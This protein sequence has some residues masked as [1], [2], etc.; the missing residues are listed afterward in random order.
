ME[1]YPLTMRLQGKQRPSSEERKQIQVRRRELANQ[2]DSTYKLLSDKEEALLETM[3]PDEAWMERLYGLSLESKLKGDTL[4]RARG[5]QLYERVDD[6]LRATYRGQR[7]ANN[8]FPLQVVKVGDMVPE[9]IE[10]KD[11]LGNSH[12]LQELR[13]KFLL[14][15]FW[16]S[17]C[18]P[19]I[20]SFPEMKEISKQMADSLKVVSISQDGEKHWKKASAKYDITWHNW[21]DLQR[22]NG[23]FA[24]FGVQGIPD[25]FLVSPEGK[26]IANKGGYGKGVLKPFVLLNMEKAGKQPTYRTE[27]DKRIIDYPTVAEEHIS[28][29]YIRRVELT[30]KET[31]VTFRVFYPSSQWFRISDESH[32]ITDNGEKL[33]IRS[34]TNI[35]LNKKCY[36]PE[37]N[38]MEF[39][40]HFPALPANAASFS[41]YEEENKPD[42]CWRMIGVKVKSAE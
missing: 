18:G 40:L 12:R 19:C 36:T 5:I 24:R 33:P 4:A 26:V 42:D 2:L 1:Y 37:S 41:Y 7:I 8:L 34:A 23:I 39:T 28:T 27:G 10:L 17:G 14:L 13:G 15:D 6:R 3:T 25:Y 38:V 9:D 35:T 30:D 16:S 22:E 21:N 29:M 11:T 20:M 32:L 31:A